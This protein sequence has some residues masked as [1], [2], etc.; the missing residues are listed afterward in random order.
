[1]LNINILGIYHQK[2]DKKIQKNIQNTL[3]LYA[4][5][6]KIILNLNLDNE[7]YRQQK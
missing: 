4:Y 3:H 6:Q 7:Y 2:S 5:I 1:M